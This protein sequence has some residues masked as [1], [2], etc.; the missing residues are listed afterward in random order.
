M[1]VICICICNINVAYMCTNMNTCNIYNCNIRVFIFEAVWYYAGTT[2]APSLLCRDNTRTIPTMQGQ[3]THHHTHP[4]HNHEHACLYDL[5]MCM[6][7]CVVKLYAC[8]R[9]CMHT[10]VCVS[11]CVCV[12]VC[13]CVS[14]YLTFYI[15]SHMSG[16]HTYKNNTHTHAHTH[17]LCDAGAKHVVPRTFLTDKFWYKK[18]RACCLCGLLKTPDMYFLYFF[19]HDTFLRP[20]LCRLLRLRSYMFFLLSLSLSVLFV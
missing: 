14:S 10:C 19:P 4:F 11:V 7:V 12:C 18:L 2:H 5:Y 16:T 6:W 20:E 17:T 1:F 3:H 13:V 15:T 8:A 9:T